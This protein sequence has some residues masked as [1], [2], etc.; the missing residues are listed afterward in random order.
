MF[1]QLVVFEGMQYF[2]TVVCVGSM[3]QDMTTVQE[4]NDKGYNI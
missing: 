3:R 1:L 2:N 4:A